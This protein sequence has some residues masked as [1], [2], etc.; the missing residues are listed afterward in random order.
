MLPLSLSVW[1]RVGS[2]V[3]VQRWAVL[4]DGARSVLWRMLWLA[5]CFAE[6]LWQTHT[7]FLFVS[8]PL[9]PG[10]SPI[11]LPG[12][13]TPGNSWLSPLLFAC[14][15]LPLGPGF[16]ASAASWLHV[17]PAPLIPSIHSPGVSVTQEQP[18]GLAVILSPF[19]FGAPVYNPPPFPHLYHCS[20]PLPPS[21]E[22]GKTGLGY[23]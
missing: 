7:C 18:S 22:G 6:S 19:S 14:W 12:S 16:A 2:R 11:L 9:L 1:Q 17:F 13:L 8:Q 15:S 20:Q 3:R 4:P 23:F 21:L 10:C 5:L